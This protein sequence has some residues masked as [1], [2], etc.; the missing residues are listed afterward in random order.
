MGCD[1]ALAPADFQEWTP[2]LL[3]HLRTYRPGV[4]CFHGLTAYRNFARYA[5][6]L[7]EKGF[8]LGPQV[9]RIESTRLFVVPNPSPAN[10]HFRLEDIVTWYD[11]LAD[12]LQ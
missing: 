2:I 8:A 11:R 12:Y 6:G 3:D 7:E 9:Q 5:P 1:A 10:A 4:A